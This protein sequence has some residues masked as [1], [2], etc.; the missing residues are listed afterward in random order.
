MD[1]N[2]LKIILTVLALCFLISC[3]IN[4]PLENCTASGHK[5]IGND[6]LIVSYDTFKV[7]DQSFLITSKKIC[8]VF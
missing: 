4:E 7:S 5:I 8:K 2:K 3:S 1:T 6:Y